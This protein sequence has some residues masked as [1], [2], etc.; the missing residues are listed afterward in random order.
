MYCIS[1]YVCLFLLCDL[2]F[3][4]EFLFL[5]LGG[6]GLTGGGKGRGKRDRSKGERGKG[7]STW[8]CI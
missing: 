2:A 1:S 5:F 3:F 6:G 4:V 7:R 8:L